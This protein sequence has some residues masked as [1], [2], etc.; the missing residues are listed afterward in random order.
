TRAVTPGSTSRAA[1]PQ[2][3]GSPKTTSGA[4]TH[5]A[6]GVDAPFAPPVNKTRPWIFAA[7]GAALVVVIG[8]V[9][10]MSGGDG[11]T[12]DASEEKADADKAATE[13]P[14]AH[15]PQKDLPEP[16]KLAPQVTAAPQTPVEKKPEPAE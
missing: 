6:V 7:A 15:E 13:G 4:V 11:E 2:G 10:V 12:A 9:A 8:T 5:A 1:T 3:Q 14:S 16:E